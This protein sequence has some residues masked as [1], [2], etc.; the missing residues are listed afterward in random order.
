MP[1]LIRPATQADQP[2]ITAIVRAAGLN[3]FSLYWP[4]FLVA[5]EGGRVIGVAQIKPHGDGSRELASLAVIP[6]EQGQGIGAALIAA[7][8][9]GER[10]ALHLMC[11]GHLEGYYARFGFR[12]IGA[13]EMPPYF[14]RMTRIAGFFF[15]IAALFGEKHHIIIMRREAFF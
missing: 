7:L 2:A 3:P 9:A 14:R 13:A 11:A 12:R 8:L 4:R 1:Y 15:G 5:E 6:E 10:G